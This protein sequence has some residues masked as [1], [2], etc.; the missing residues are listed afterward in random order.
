VTFGKEGDVATRTTL[1]PTK[2]AVVKVVHT[3]IYV[4]MA[5]ATL[6]VVA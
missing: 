5:S 6:Y 1:Q 3:I 2:M 4:A